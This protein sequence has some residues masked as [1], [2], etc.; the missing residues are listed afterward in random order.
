MAKD[1]VETEMERVSAGTV[2]RYVSTLSTAF[3][4]LIHI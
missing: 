4:S 1:F 2:I 3:L